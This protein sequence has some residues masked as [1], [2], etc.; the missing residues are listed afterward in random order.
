MHPQTGLV[1][2]KG[3]EARYLR[4]SLLERRNCIDSRA[5]ELLKSQLSK[6]G[7]KP[8]HTNAQ[9]RTKED[10]GYKLSCMQFVVFNERR[11][12]RDDWR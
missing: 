8:L 5:R 10:P 1:Q 3:V 9:W 4:C 12:E 11:G 7:D 6:S 2:F